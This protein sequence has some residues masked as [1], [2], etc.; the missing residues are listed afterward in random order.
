M[1][2]APK[3]I[4]LLITTFNYLRYSLLINFLL[5]KNLQHEKTHEIQKYVNVFRIV[6]IK[7]FLFIL[8]NELRLCT[9]NHVK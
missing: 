8:S 3:K 2:D 7:T 4:F 1:E 9:I 6:K 5:E